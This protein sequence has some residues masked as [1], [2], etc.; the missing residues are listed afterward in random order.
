MMTGQ[1]IICVA[2]PKWEGDYL[3]STVELM[4]ELARHNELL[5][6]DYPYTL[7]DLALSGL[8]GPS[9]PTAPLL[10]LR[11]R[12]RLQGFEGGSKLWLLT[13]PPSWPINWLGQPQSYDR[14]LSWNAHW[15]RRCIRRAMEQLGFQ[16]P[17]VI[18]AFNPAL[19]N[20]LAGQLDESCLVYYCYDEISA[21]NWIGKHGTRHE[22]AFLRRA[23][24]TIVSSAPLLAAKAPLAQRCALVK[25]GVNLEHFSQPGPRPLDLPPA[26]TPLIGYLGSLDERLDYDLLAFL[27]QRLPSCRFALVGRLVSSEAEARLGRLPNV[28]LLGAKP[29]AALS[30]YVAAFDLCL[31]PFIKSRLTAG[32]YPLKINEYLALGK[33][34]V[35][36][37]FSDLSDFAG[38]IELAGSPAQFL[39]AV[40]QALDAPLSADERASRRAF[41]LANSWAQRAADFGAAILATQPAISNP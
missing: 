25:N 20:A 38:L 24:L 5:Y 35:A 4:K 26:D 3:K 15:A 28:D 7:K 12:L 39:A 11:P 13:L 1:Q 19:G 22:Q 10:G 14:L 34:V 16:R 18:N 6:V 37:D 40:K 30:S 17:I 33:P 23:D 8:G 36:T 41:A 32:I 9:V 29:P 31:I 27:A 21:A 2:F